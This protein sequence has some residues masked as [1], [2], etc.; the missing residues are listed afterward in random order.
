M[1]PPVF[2]VHRDSVYDLSQLERRWSATPVR[3]S[4]EI[5]CLVIRTAPGVH[6]TPTAIVLTPE[7][8]V[9]GDRWATGTEP[10]QDAQVSL[11]ERRVAALLAGD[12]TRWHTPGDNI[13][14]DLDL[15]VTALPVGTRLT[16]GDAV[17]EITAKPHA[18]CAKFRE[19]LGD[20]A[21]RW[22]NGRDVRHRR[23]R[24]VYARVLVGGTAR[25][26]DRLERTPTI[27]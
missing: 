18:G 4:G 17:L 21:L 23:L 2:A 11:I 13:V 26:G 22:V 27:T 6:A 12:P 24:G 15:S 20:D 19:R 3:I 9:V 5:H 25:I 10:H 16:A 7:H 8:G 1:T 14:V